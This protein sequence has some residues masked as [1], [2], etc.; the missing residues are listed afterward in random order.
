M[1]RILAALLAGAEYHG[2]VAALRLDAWGDSWGLLKEAS[3]PLN[4]EPFSKLRNTRQFRLEPFRL[5]I[6]GQFR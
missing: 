1:F 6:E 4:L 3:E 5:T 2:V